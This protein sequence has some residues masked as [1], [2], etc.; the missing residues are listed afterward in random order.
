MGIEPWRLCPL[1]ASTVRAL[2]LPSSGG[3]VPSTPPC[4]R[5]S[6]ILPRVHC[7]PSHVEAH[8]VAQALDGEQG[9]GSR[10]SQLGERP[11]SDSSRA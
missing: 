2:A 4:N 10:A 6:D 9:Y 8:A 7:M 11:V 3:S 1:A 5:I